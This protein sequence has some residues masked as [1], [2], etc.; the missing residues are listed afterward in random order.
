VNRPTWRKI[1]VPDKPLIS[2]GATCY[3][4]IRERPRFFSIILW[5][6]I[7]LTP[8]NN[9]KPLRP[10]I[11]L[12]DGV[13]HLVSASGRVPGFLSAE[14]LGSTGS[15]TSAVVFRI[16]FIRLSLRYYGLVRLPSHMT[17]GIMLFAFPLWCR[18]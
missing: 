10:I 12:A 3:R 16:G 14:A 11:F 9:K 4:T 5:V 6:Q 2:P 18:H 8:Y 1:P 17:F 15:A 13:G 7:P